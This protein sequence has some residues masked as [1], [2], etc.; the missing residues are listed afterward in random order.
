DADADVAHRETQGGRVDALVEG[1]Q[2]H[3]ADGA[4]QGEG[5]AL[6][7]EAPHDHGRPH[8]QVGSLDHSMT[9]PRI[10]NLARAELLAQ[11]TMAMI[12]AASK[13]G[14]LPVRLPKT[15][16]ISMALA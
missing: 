12:S 1:L 5:G 3:Q 15:T 2:P 8:G 11:P 16:I 6:H 14:C 10:R 4:K 9:S 13:Y 7:R